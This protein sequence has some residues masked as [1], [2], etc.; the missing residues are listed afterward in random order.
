MQPTSTCDT[1]K[2]VNQHDTKQLATDGQTHHFNPLQTHCNMDADNAHNLVV[3]S[4]EKEI[5]DAR[6]TEEKEEKQ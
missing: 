2:Q 6:T 5:D 1:Q 4:R 3:M